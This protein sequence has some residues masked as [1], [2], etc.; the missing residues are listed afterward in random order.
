[1]TAGARTHP[2]RDELAAASTAS[3]ERQR[4]HAREA[5]TRLSRDGAPI[6]A[7]LYLQKLVE[8]E[9]ELVRRITGRR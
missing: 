1:M 9:G 5:Y 3:L 4:K 8:V 6:A 7:Y 2:Y